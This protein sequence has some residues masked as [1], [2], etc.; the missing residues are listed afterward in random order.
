MTSP[1]GVD[2]DLQLID[3]NGNL[4][5]TSKRGAGQTEDIYIWADVTGDWRIDVY[6]YGGEGQYSFHVNVWWGGGGCPYLYAYDG[7]DYVCEGLLN[8]HD[9][10]G[11][12]VA[13]EHTLVTAPKRVD[14]AFQFRLTEHIQTHSRIDQVRLYAILEDK[15]LLSLSLVSAVHSES[16]NVLPELLL[17]DDW[18]TET[19]G[20]KFN[21][22][23]SQSID[24]RFQ[25][26]PRSFKVVGYLLIIEGNNQI[27]KDM[28]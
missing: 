12:D 11:T 5:G 6:Q 16:G 1:A 8:I 2:F 27:I 18:K 14:D 26:Q 22:G 10:N 17:S 13:T 4:R 20:A 15:T 19:I 7:K 28:Y 9:P 3:P 24:L 25:A 23:T 21:N